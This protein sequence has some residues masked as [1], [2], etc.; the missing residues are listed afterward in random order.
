MMQS[1][2]LL[3]SALYLLNRSWQ[4]CICCICVF[5]CLF[6]C[7]VLFGL[8]WFGLVW[9]FF[10]FI[11]IFSIPVWA[12]MGPIWCKLGD[13][14]VLPPSFPVH[15]GWYSAPYTIPWSQS[16]NLRGWADRDTPLFMMGQFCMA[17]QNVANLSCCCHQCYNAPPTTSLLSHWLFHLHK[18]SAGVHECQWVPF[19]CVEKLHTFTSYSFPR[20]VPFYQ[21]APL[22]PSVTQQ[23]NVIEYWREGS[24][25]TAIPATNIHLWL[26]RP[27]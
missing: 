26:C 27:T 7:L 12:F 18:H 21:M 20:Q 5:V 10:I 2:K 16:S 1:S 8:V 17:I 11:F 3:P 15:W 9:W 13:I 19:F 4:I 6:V 24:T 14:P 25:S 23:Q 22:L